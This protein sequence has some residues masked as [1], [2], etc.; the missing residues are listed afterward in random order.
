MSFN[1]FTKSKN[2]FLF[3]FKPTTHFSLSPPDI[4]SARLLFILFSRPVKQSK[5]F[6]R[7]ASKCHRSRLHASHTA[8]R[9]QKIPTFTAKHTVKCQGVPLGTHLHLGCVHRKQ[10]KPIENRAGVMIKLLQKIKGITRKIGV[11]RIY[12]VLKIFVI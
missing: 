3:T 6:T 12:S 11:D 2:S 8:Q 5:N 1:C 4:F 10:C 9:N 7:S